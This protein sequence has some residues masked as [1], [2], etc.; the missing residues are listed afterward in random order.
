MK[1]YISGPITGVPDY[2]RV[3]EQAEENLRGKGWDVI[4][5]A[6]VNA[7]LPG[8]TTREQYMRMCFTMLDMA[9]AI[10]LLQGWEESNGA[11]IEQ[12]YALG[13]DKIIMKEGNYIC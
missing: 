10:Y 12:G 2:M 3:F 1:V 8:S 13:T 7:A 6:K 4:N 5:P 11:C 9:D